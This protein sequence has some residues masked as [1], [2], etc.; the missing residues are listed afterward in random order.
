MGQIE[1]RHLASGWLLDPEVAKSAFGAVA[2]QPGVCDIGQLL[3]RGARP[4]GLSSAGSALAFDISAVDPA[5]LAYIDAA[6]GGPVMTPHGIVHGVSADPADSG[7]GPWEWANMST[8][9]QAAIRSAAREF[10]GQPKP[11]TAARARIVF[12]A[13]LARAWSC[14]MPRRWAAPLLPPPDLDQL[15][16]DHRRSGHYAYAHMEEVVVQVPQFDGTLSP[17]L[18]REL[19]HSGDAA[20]VLPYDPDSDRVL[21]I[22]QFR[23]GAWG[24]GDPSPWKLEP[25]AGM[26]DPGEDAA[27]C[28]RREAIEEA[29]LEMNDMLPIPGG[30]PSPGYTVGIFH[31]FVGL[32]DLSQRQGG[33]AGLA[34]E[35]ENIRSHVLGLDQAIDMVDAGDIDV[36]PLVAMLLWLS[37]YRDRLRAGG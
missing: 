29:N 24:L 35:S 31:C 9:L 28:A 3:D 23:F 13:A 14:H 36:L 16:I 19:Y 1:Q 18:S 10:F 34:S 22:E 4:P 21:L 11:Q 27:T 7:S 30:Y 5:V 32:C 15:V 33:I 2:A 17:P 26:V 37:R 6:L 20:L 25:I 8:A 12:G